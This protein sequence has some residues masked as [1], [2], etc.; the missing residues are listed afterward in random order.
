ML[1]TCQAGFEALLAR[2][3]TELHHAVI[4]EQGPGWVRTTSPVEA[5]ALTFPWLTLR[6]PIEVKGESVNALASR[7]AEFFLTSL[8]GERIETAWPSVWQGPQETV[9][10][11]RR[12][13]AVESAFG[14]LLKKKLSRVA[15]LAVADV[16]RGEGAARGLFAYFVDFG[17]AYVAREAYVHG[18]RRMADDDLAPSRS[19]LKVEEAFV[20]LG[21][22]P[23]EGETV[24]D[25]G[26]APG[27][28]SYSAAKRGARVVAIDNGPLKGGA[29]DNPRIEHLREDAF[30]FAP[31]AG[32]KFDW[33]F[34][35]MV[36]EPHHVLQHIVAPWLAQGWC[37]NFV[38]N[39]KFGRVDAVGLL[40][41]LRLPDS[42]F[43]KHAPGLRVRHLYHDR[44][45]FTLVGS[46]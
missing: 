11:G 9:G 25:L 45:E 26:A 18:Q 12:L 38:I 22:E 4:A 42:P 24:C 32:E 13:S 19:Y 27:G 31:R 29:L 43:A 3:L 20:V 30:K 10:L 44:E 5:P 41:E 17:R 8:R 14:E 37:R 40:R 6:D 33:L 2:E 1:L 36:E 21:R 39:L 7:V 46:R 15:K 23:A 34:C 16:P 35:D 28:W